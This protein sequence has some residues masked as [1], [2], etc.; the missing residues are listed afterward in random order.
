MPIFDRLRR[1]VD[2]TKFKAD[3]LL[4]INRIQGEI[5]SLH[6]RIAEV[7]RRIAGKAIELHQIGSLSGLLPAGS[8]V[9]NGIQ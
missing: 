7:Q 8:G 4:R 1:G 6:Q 3:Q 2:L 9:G 5:D